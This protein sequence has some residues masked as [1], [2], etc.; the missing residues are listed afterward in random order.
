MTE[1]STKT[2]QKILTAT[3]KKDDDF[4]LLKIVGDIKSENIDSFKKDLE[5]ASKTMSD[6]YA[7]LGHKVKVLLD[8][9]NFS[10][11]Y[12]AEALTALVDFARKDEAIVE[13]TASFGGSD[14]VKMA[15]EAA[16]ALSHRT[17]IQIF[18]TEEE[19]KAWLLS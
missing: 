5:E 2:L 19:A 8:V 11:T 1:D 7:E 15:G 3:F 14:K 17:N 4:V 9:S 12:N 13:K 16:V 18:D 10:G 6:A